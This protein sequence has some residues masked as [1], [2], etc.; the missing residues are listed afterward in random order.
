MQTIHLIALMGLALGVGLI[1]S[2]VII[3]ARRQHWQRRSYTAG[4][5]SAN[6]TRDY[7]VRALRESLAGSLGTAQS[8][9]EKHKAEHEAVMQDADKR[10]ALFAR[11]ALT[12]EDLTALQ[13]AAS[14]LELAAA[15]FSSLR[16][17]DKARHARH[18]QAKLLNIRE[19]LSKE[20]PESFPK[21]VTA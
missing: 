17:E 3:A 11:R 6:A 12:S 5:A 7:E 4:Q 18:A 10:I 15:T 14:Q 8:L 21:G 9:R 1:L 13:A 2:T 20:L 19:R 16:A